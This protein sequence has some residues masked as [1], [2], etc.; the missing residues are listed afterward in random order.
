MKLSKKILT[1]AI[2]IIALIGLYLN[3]QRMED[4]QS[5][6]T[7][8]VERKPD[9]SNAMMLDLDKNGIVTTELLGNHYFDYDSDG[10]REKTAWVGK[11]DGLLVRDINN[12]GKINNGSEL[13]GNHTILANGERA[14]NGLRH[15][16][17]LI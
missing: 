16:R 7:E 4:K 3:A 10:L 15:W 5:D 17:S 6:H 13:F 11:G 14:K 8:Q 9:L 1:P 12:D 2:V